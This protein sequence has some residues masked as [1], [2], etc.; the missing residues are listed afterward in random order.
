MKKRYILLI[1]IILVL[2]FYFISSIPQD[3]TVDISNAHILKENIKEIYNSGTKNFVKYHFVFDCDTVPVDSKLYCV[4]KVYDKNGKLLDKKSA[5]VEPYRNDILIEGSYKNI[6]KIR[7]YIYQDK[8]D[9]KSLF[10]ALGYNYLVYKNSTSKVVKD[11]TVFINTYE[12]VSTPSYTDYSS[13]SSY[14][15]DD[16]YYYDSDYD[17]GSSY[18]SEEVSG[19]SYVASKNSDKF[20]TSSC[21]HAERIKSGNRIYFSSRQDALDSGYSPCKHCDP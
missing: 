1:L 12:P 9:F 17:S 13:T 21:G 15:D 7:Y 3:P 14:Y 20:H 19:G 16:S 10:D 2:G 6:K 11:H 8:G 5:L 18:A 4:F